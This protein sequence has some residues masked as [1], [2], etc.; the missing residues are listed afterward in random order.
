VFVLGERVAGGLY[1]QQPSLSDLDD[2]DL[3]ATMDFRDVFG[4]LLAAV[5]H[6]D[7]ARYLDGYQGSVLPLFPPG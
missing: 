2:G 6:A 5:L 3:K 1:G 7:P 4:T